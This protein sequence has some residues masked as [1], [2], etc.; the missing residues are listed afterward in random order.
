MIPRRSIAPPEITR[1]ARVKSHQPPAATALGEQ[2]ID[3]FKQSV[4]RR[5]TKLAAIAQSW[6]ELVPPMLCDHCALDGYTRGALTVMVDSAS[7]LYELRQL[8]LAGLQDQ[9]FLACKNTGLRK[10]TLRPGRWYHGD[11]AA[12]RR[13]RFA[14]GTQGR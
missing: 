2:M 10:I 11:G 13:V 7:H 1:L 8:L 14:P 6:L 5:Q 9:L 3:F 12:D 4:V